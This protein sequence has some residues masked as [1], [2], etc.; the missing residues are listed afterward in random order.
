[1]GRYQTLLG[2]LRLSWRRGLFKIAPGMPV[3]D[4]GCGAG[5]VS[6]LAAEL[7]G[8]TGEALGIDRNKDVLAVAAERARVAGFPQI[9]FE[10]ASAETF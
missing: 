1:M 5:D 3:L 2:D 8:P 9:R 6:M 7:V 4:L 10:Q